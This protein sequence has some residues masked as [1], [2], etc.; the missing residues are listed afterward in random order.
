ATSGANGAWTICVPVQ[1]TYTLELDT[2][3]LPEGIAL[4]E[5]QDNPRDVTF[6]QTSILSVIFAFGEGI[7]VQQQVFGQNLLNRLVA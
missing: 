5:C 6:S 3:T 2:S 1:C 4:A 7:V